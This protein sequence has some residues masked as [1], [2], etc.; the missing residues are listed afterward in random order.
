VASVRAL[1][2]TLDESFSCQGRK[3]LI[4]ATTKDKDV[5]GML[6]LL[7]P[8]FDRVLLT[9]YESNPRGVSVEELTALADDLGAKNYEP[10][11]T[12]ATA[13]QQVRRGLEPDD[14]ACVT[15]SF[16]TAGELRRLILADRPAG[17]AIPATPTGS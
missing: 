15:G 14:L 10:T 12:P 6:E 13:W 9:R 7:L 11:P 2:H 17:T 1:L 3:T 8:Y 4:F 5:R 16:F